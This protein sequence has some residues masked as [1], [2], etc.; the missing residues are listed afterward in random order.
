MAD[1]VLTSRDGAVLTITLN[2]PEVYN[3]F[4]R[5]L[6]L[7][8]REALTEAADPA[9]RAVVN[10]TFR[11]DAAFPIWVPAELKEYYKAAQSVDEI[12]ATATYSNVRRFQ[13]NTNEKIAKP[14]G[15][16]VD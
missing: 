12:L 1:E 9:V 6:H 15:V 16:T 5:E 11:Q 7:A 3:A 10:V 14:P 4:N 2:R 8:L 13:V